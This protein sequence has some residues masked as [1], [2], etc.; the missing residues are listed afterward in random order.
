MIVVVVVEVAALMPCETPLQVLLLSGWVDSSGAGRRGAAVGA[1]RLD[2]VG[3]SVSA[4]GWR[5][6]LPPRS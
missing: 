3:F 1:S 6:S 4:R 5:A 2:E